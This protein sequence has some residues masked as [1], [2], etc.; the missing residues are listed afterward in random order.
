MQRRIGDEM[1]IGALCYESEVEPG[2]NLVPVTHGSP[3][4][5]DRR[6]SVDGLSAH[7]IEFNARRVGADQGVEIVVVI[8]AY[9]Q[10]ALLGEAI[11]SALHQRTSL[12]VFIV[13]V[14]DGCPLRQT[15]EVGLAYARDYPGRVYY[16]RRQNGGLSAA[17]N[18]GIAFALD[19]LAG[20]QAIYFLDAD[21]RIYPDFLQRAWD[22]LNAADA[23]VGWVYPDVDMFGFNENYSLRGDYSLFMLLLE[24][25]CEAGSL[26]RRSVFERGV[27]FD[28]SMR[29]GFEDWDFWLQAAEAGFEG[30]HLPQ[31][32]FRYRRRAES[33]LTS[34]ERVRQSILVYMRQKH[35]EM[36]RIDKLL[37]LE[38]T[39][40]PRFSVREIDLDAVEL[41]LDPKL[42][43]SHRLSLADD[44]D[45]FIKSCLHPAVYAY[46]DIICYTKSANLGALRSYGVI[47]NVFWLAQT[48]L[49][50]KHFVIVEI[51]P[52]EGAELSLTVAEGDIV[53]RDVETA[54]MIFGR[55]Q[56]FRE[57]VF[58]QTSAWLRTF[59]MGPAAPNASK[60]I[61]ALPS[62]PELESPRDSEFVAEA[63]FLEADALRELWRRRT[64]MGAEWRTDARMPRHNVANAYETFCNTRHVFPHL[65][66]NDGIDIGLILP[67]FSFGGVEKVILNYARELR[68]RGFRPHLFVTAVQQMHFEPEMA[69][70]FESL[71]FVGCKEVEGANWRNG[72]FG[73][74]SPT[75]GPSS[76]LV[77]LLATMR[78]VLNTHSL[79]AHAVMA[80]LQKL[81]VK[82]Y[83]GLHLVER[84]VFDQPLGN[85][86]VALAYE[87]AYDG[88]VVISEQ[89]RGWCIG[90]GIPREKVSLVANAP[91]YPSSPTQVAN[92]LARRRDKDS[93]VLNVVFLGRLDFQKGLDRLASVVRRTLSRR[94]HW[95]IIGKAIVDSAGGE[96]EGLDV[97]IEPPIGTGAELDRLY[98]W[99]DVVVLCSRFEGVPLTILE[100]QRLGCVALATDV[101]AVSEIVNHGVDGLLVSSR[102]S[103]EEIVSDFV[104]WI[105]TLADDR[106]RCIAIGSAAAERVE[107]VGWSVTMA[108]WIASLTARN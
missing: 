35:K 87:H 77:G 37:K 11:E 14:D 75:Y 89:L 27:R 50:N 28:E 90:L 49:E 82:T 17:R 100:A 45:R 104:S 70:V 15:R 46:P 2:S 65:A 91:A 74:W 51:V 26:V 71:N 64:P 16:V 52:A 25:Y 78:I 53:E 42:G 13:V 107:K 9:K 38:A 101:G 57:C 62:F 39:E 95:R 63:L 105:Q 6:A 8:P 80:R 59:G 7:D 54:A 81:G 73:A 22:A 32:G 103:E 66:S 20:F 97:V 29:L 85:P 1:S 99:A 106:G 108:E 31:P 69:E 34:S 98:E 21:N 55:T 40:L 5:P 86:H 23:N 19:A 33:M 102:Q 18:T 44:R 48:Q 93:R 83:V 43:S 41:A 47:R 10:P 94:V 30:R 68:A 76:H 24:N 3:I 96:L 56:I 36:F 61:L 92:S 67:L 84:G 60:M 79:G 72:Y 88:F 4:A 58:D 12:N